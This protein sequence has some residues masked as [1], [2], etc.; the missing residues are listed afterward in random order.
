MMMLI[1][2]QEVLDYLLDKMENCSFLSFQLYKE[3]YD[4]VKFMDTKKVTHIRAFGRS[5]PIEVIVDKEVE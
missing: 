1:N 2:K 5:E 3:V 4:Y